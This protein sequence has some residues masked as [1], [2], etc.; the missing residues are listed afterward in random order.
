ME[1]AS[2]MATQLTADQKFGVTKSKY[3]SDAGSRIDSNCS[4]E[5]SSCY[6]NIDETVGFGTKSR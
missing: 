2:E 6:R 1:S 5:K 3:L 4:I